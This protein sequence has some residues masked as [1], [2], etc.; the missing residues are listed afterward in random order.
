MTGKGPTSRVISK[1]Q[2]IRTIARMMADG[3]WVSGVSIWK[4]MKRWGVSETVVKTDAAEASRI[5]RASV[6]SGEELRD[7]IKA[8][9]EGIAQSLEDDRRI[10]ERVTKEVMDGTDAPKGG[11]RLFTYGSALRAR[12]DAARAKSDALRLLAGLEALEKGRTAGGGEA[13]RFKALSDDELIDEFG[14]RK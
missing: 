5:I 10:M 11:Q 2:R 9:L 12:T 14:K 1:E 3:R 7:R 13:D 8:Q 4:M 6:I